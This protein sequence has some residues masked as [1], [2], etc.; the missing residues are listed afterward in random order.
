MTSTASQIRSF[1]DLRRWAAGST[2][3]PASGDAF[4]AARAD[5]PLANGP[6][7]AGL[8]LLPQGNG[9]VSALSG[10]EFIIVEAG[11]VRIEQAGKRFTLTEGQSLLLRDGAI[12]DWFADADARILFMRRSGG[13]AGD[14]A[15]IPVDTGAPLEA[16]GA[17]LAELLVGPTPQCR[18]HGD[19][20]SDDGEYMVGTWDSTPYYRR[21]MAYRHFELMYLLDG[22]VTFIDEAGEE[23]TFHKGDIF[24][25]EQ[26][27]QCSWDSQVHLKK[28]YCIYRPA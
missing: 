2:V 19:Y 7:S 22:S 12:F 1:I 21:A 20:K 27:A 14:G 18:N 26:G 9:T 8:I 6:I 3:A 17:P 4:L 11:V 23:G 5:L 10:E 13:P 24:L 25:V 15:I 28:V 16:S